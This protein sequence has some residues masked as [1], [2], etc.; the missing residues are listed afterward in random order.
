MWDKIHITFDTDWAPEEAVLDA[1][2]LIDSYNVSATFFATGNY[3]CLQNTLNNIEVALH[4]NFNSVLNG[5]GENFIYIF[6]ALHNIYP[7]AKGFRSHSLTQ[8]SHILLHAK[9]KGMVYDSNLYHPE[10]GQPYLD[11]S[12]LIRF[13]HVWVDLGHILDENAFEI[14]QLPFQKSKTNIIDFHPIHTFVNTNTTAFYNSV[15]HLTSNLNELKKQSNN[16][17]KGVRTLFIDLLEFIKL[18]KIK[19]QTLYQLYKEI[20]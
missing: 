5:S 4:P 6:D 13:T 8:S 18:H 17:K 2:R 16:D 19:T 1:I 14:N 11:Y 3:K 15:K 7:N 20:V 9:E 10:Q 12:G